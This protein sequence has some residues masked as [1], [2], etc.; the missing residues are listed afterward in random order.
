MEQITDKKSDR[1]IRKTKKALRD[2]LT[3]LMYTKSMKDITVKELT[4][5]VDLNRGTF[6]L[7]YNDI[8]DMI[9]QLETELISE[10]EKALSSY[11]PEVISGPPYPLLENVFEFLKENADLCTVLLSNNGDIAF[12]NK[13]KDIVCQ[14]CFHDWFVMLPA[15]STKHFDYLYSFIL[16]GCIGLFETWL[17]NGLKETPKEMSTLAADMILFGLNMYFLDSEKRP[18]V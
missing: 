11:T 5:E 4:D 6:Y 2:G 13:V 17:T 12:V 14:K 7:H 16:S 15:Y 10:F 18:D 8:F 9:E 1:R 3:S